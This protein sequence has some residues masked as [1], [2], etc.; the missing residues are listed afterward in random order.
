MSCCISQL[1]ACVSSSTPP[2]RGS[3]SASLEESIMREGQSISSQPTSLP[4]CVTLIKINS[5]VKSVTWLITLLSHSNSLRFLQIVDNIIQV[6][7]L[8]FIFMFIFDMMSVRAFLESQNSM[9]NMKRQIC[10]ARMKYAFIIIYWVW[11]SGLIY[12]FYGALLR[13]FKYRSF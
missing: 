9:E 3:C 10:L 6:V 8:T 7:I 2:S 1:T 4:S 5:I 12:I 13:D 11:L